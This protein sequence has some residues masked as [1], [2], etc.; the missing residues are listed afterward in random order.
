MNHISSGLKL[1]PPIASTNTDVPA[2]NFKA[3]FYLQGSKM[4]ISYLTL[5]NFLLY[6][7]M[8]VGKGEPQGPGPPWFLAIAGQS[9]PGLASLQQEL[10]L[11]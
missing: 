6:Y 1:S 11:Q 7:N 10:F 9:R 4:L 3:V 5:C 8:G 2:I